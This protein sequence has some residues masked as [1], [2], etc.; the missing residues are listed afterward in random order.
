MRTK[1]RLLTHCSLAISMAYVISFFPLYRWPQGGSVT[2]ASML[3]IFFVAI[4]YGWRTGV[5]AGVVYGILQFIQDPWFLSP[6]QFAL[7][8]PLAFASIGL[9]GLF[10]DTDGN[11]ILLAIFVGGFFRFTC[12]LVS[13]AVFFG[14]YAPE[15]M[16][17]WVYSAT[18][19][20]SVQGMEVLVCIVVAFFMI[21]AGNWKRIDDLLK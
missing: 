7:D 20:G 5:L 10:K 3:P 16:N 14:S 11:K 12:H 15:G 1:T 4:H 17:V 18:V 6:L 8:Y 2:A 9:A 19:N 13:G 21:R